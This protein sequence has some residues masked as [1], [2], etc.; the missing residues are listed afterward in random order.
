MVD[1]CSCKPSGWSAQLHE[2]MHNDNGPLSDIVLLDDYL[3]DNSQSYTDFSAIAIRF[4][5]LLE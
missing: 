5:S 2:Y 4:V 3:L 1:L